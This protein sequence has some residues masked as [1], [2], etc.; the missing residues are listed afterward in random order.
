MTPA[1]QFQI[2]TP[3]QDTLLGQQPP[4]SSSSFTLAPNQASVGQMVA[5]YSHVGLIKAGEKGEK[6]G[7]KKGM[8]ETKQAVAPLEGRADLLCEETPPPPP[9]P[10][11]YSLTIPPFLCAP[12]TSSCSL[13]LSLPPLYPPPDVYTFFPSTCLTAGCG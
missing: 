13:S 7:L 12:L 4:T 5:L 6:Q 11:L 9:P 3:E 10:N 1:F 8:E 2:T